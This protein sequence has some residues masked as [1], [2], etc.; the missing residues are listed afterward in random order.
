MTLADALRAGTRE[1]HESAEGTPFVGD[2]L[3]ARVPVSAYV[4][5]LVQY[6][7]VYAA[8]EETGRALR[9]AGRCG[10][11]ADPA[12]ERS[13]AIELDLRA[14]DGDDWRGRPVVPAAAE[15]ADRIRAVG[16]RPGLW[17]AHAWTRYLGD[18]SG[19]QAIRV[20]LEDRH[21][22]GDDALHFYAFDVGRVKPY[23]DRYRALLDALPLTP[24]EVDAA[25]DEARRAFAL[26]SATMR[27]VGDHHP[28]T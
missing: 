21:G 27:Q 4:D 8:L 20:A 18:L 25:V 10:G 23:K 17:A 26:T 6:R 28:R 1:A 13:A 11:L 15:H 3:E 9:D 5:L 16:D 12:L 14:L 2:L 22:L 19:G 24:D 7:A